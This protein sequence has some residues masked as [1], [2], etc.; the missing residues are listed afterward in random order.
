MRKSPLSV[1]SASVLFSTLTYAQT[2]EPTVELE[3]MVIDVSKEAGKYVAI[4]PI[5]LKDDSPLYE[6]AQSI[7]VLTPQQVEQKQASTVAELLENVA[8]VNSGVQG[9]RGWDDFIIRGQVSS[10]Q[11][12]G[13]G[14]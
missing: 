3:T 2:Q 14:M 7:T 6:T 9:R 12:Y 1:L 5:S 11:T 8:G 4:K 10:A 13:D